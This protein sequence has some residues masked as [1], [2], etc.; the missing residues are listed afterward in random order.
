MY[1]KSAVAVIAHKHTRNPGEIQL[2]LIISGSRIDNVF[3]ISMASKTN[4]PS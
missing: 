1:R 4:T 3:G 2:S